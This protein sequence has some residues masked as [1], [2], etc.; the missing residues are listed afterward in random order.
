MA[1]VFL[2][3]TARELDG[4]HENKSRHG[5]LITLEKNNFPDD[6]CGESNPQRFDHEFGALPLSYHDPLCR[7]QW[8]RISLLESWYFEPSQPQRITSGLKQSSICLPFTM[9][10][11]HQITNFQKTLKS[12]LA[13]IYIKQNIH[14]HQTQTFRTVIP[15]GIAFIKKK[16]HI[17][18]GH[19]GIVDHSV[20]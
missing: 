12:V 20:D 3:A 7:G 13:Q 11:S 15:L 2:R 9:H 17:R 8:Q 16:K 1:R 5:K 4:N 19:A 10:V 14:K 18:L 6:S